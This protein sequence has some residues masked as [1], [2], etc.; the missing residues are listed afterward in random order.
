MSSSTPRLIGS[1]SIGCSRQRITCAAARSANSAAASYATWPRVTFIPTWNAHLATFYDVIEEP[2]LGDRGMIQPEELKANVPLKW[3]PGRGADV[4]K[5][6]CACR[7]GE[8]ATVERLIT[9]DP[10]LVRCSHAYRTPLYFAV[11]E[12]RL[13]VAALL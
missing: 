12:N 7:D 4:W 8:L 3:S 6:F 13:E 10:S 1:K 2:A 11:R 5:M 9:R